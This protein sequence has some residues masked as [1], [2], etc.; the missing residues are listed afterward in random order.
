MLLQL[1]HRSPATFALSIIAPISFSAAPKYTGGWLGTG[2]K[3]G[4]ILLMASK[5]EVYQSSSSSSSEDWDAQLAI[6]SGLT[7]AP[8]IYV[9]HISLKF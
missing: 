8:D 4:A 2:M 3:K 9:C 7:M 1:C 6:H 5:S